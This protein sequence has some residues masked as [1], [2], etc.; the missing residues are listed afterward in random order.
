MDSLST[1]VKFMLLHLTPYYPPFSNGTTQARYKLML[2]FSAADVYGLIQ[3]LVTG[4]GKAVC[5]S[6]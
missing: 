1:V 5:G 6:Y 3:M 2:S 4:P